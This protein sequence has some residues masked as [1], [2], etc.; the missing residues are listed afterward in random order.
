MQ[1]PKSLRRQFEARRR[2]VKLKQRI[3]KEAKKRDLRSGEKVHGMP[4]RGVSVLRQVNL[5]LL[6]RMQR[7]Y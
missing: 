7:G 1:R 2:K 4:P 6:E 3:A 5:Q